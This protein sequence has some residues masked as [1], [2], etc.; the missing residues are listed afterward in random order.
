MSKKK[1]PAAPRSVANALEDVATWRSEAGTKTK[2]ELAE[3]DQEV[4]N[5]HTAIKNLQQQIE[6]LRKTREDVG[7]R[8]SRVGDEEI[9]RSYNAVFAALIEQMEAVRSRASSLA[10]ADTSRAQ[11]LAEALKDPAVASLMTEYSQ[12]KTTVEPTLKALPESYRGVIMQH[13]DGVAKRLRESLERVGGAVGTV[14][15]HEIR[16]DAAFAVD[17]PDGTP[18]VVMMILPVQEQVQAAWATRTEDAQTWIAARAVQGLYAA[19][20]GA[21][22][23]QARAAFGGHQGLLAIEVEV[24]GAKLDIQ[25]KIADEINKAIAGAKEL[26]GAKITVVPRPMVVDHLLP[27]EEEG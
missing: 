10:E 3:I 15:G 14:D 1:E 21:G 19:L 7:K 2:S 9:T 25:Q 17:A 16:V 26:A 27:P 8:D 13:H 6:A 5:L 12:F 4:E 22:L 11:A 23:H 20:Q 24:S 18:E